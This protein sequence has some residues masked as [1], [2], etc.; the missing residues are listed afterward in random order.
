MASTRKNF[1]NRSSDRNSTLRNNMGSLPKYANTMH[2]LQHWHKSAFE[3]LGWMVLAKAKGYSD[4]VA[5]Y[6]KSIG[7]L[8]KSLGHVMGEYESANRKHDL[9]V[10]H[11]NVMCLQQFVE[12]H[13]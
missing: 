3:K 4:K 12:N 10:L 5:L 11:M 1:K 7:Y 8:A 6:K 9:H 13:L 2:G